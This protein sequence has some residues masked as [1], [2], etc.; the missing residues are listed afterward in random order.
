MSGKK[1]HNVFY[2]HF[3]QTLQE[4]QLYCYIGP[5]KIA[6]RVADL[7][8][9]DVRDNIYI[10]DVGAGTGLVAVEVC[11]MYYNAQVQCSI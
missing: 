7:F 1:C 10:L 6:Q 8:P 11:F 2:L 4:C 3:E 5:A 9:N